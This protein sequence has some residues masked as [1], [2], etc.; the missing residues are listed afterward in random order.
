MRDHDEIDRLLRET[1]ER[2]RARPLPLPAVDET[3]FLGSA[4]GRSASISRFLAAVAAGVLVIALV[5]IVASRTAPANPANTGIGLAATPTSAASMTTAETSPPSPAPSAATSAPSPSSTVSP[6]PTLVSP[7]IVRD[8]DAVVG[9]GNLFATDDRLRSLLYPFAGWAP[10]TVIVSVR[11]VDARDLPGSET[12]PYVPD[13]PG[14]TWVT[15]WVRVTGVWSDDALMAG[16]VDLADQPSLFELAQMPD[17]PCD[18]PTSGLPRYTG[19][20]GDAERAR[21]AFEALEAE[22]SRDPDTYSG[23]SSAVIRDPDDGRVDQAIVVGTVLEV[24]SVAQRLHAIYPYKPCILR[25]DHSARELQQA[26]EE[27]RALKQPWDVGDFEYGFG[28]VIVRVPV[29][30]DETADTLARFG[31]IITI[32]PIVSA[33]HE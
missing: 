3:M 13:L 14:G 2:W 15:S 24:E 33:L 32:R 26:A 1:G 6:A 27:V 20:P 18:P 12:D 29:L 10:N 17:V 16:R 5:A 30:D 11:G 22:I 21:E 4:A 8:G 23:I 7:A 28:R 19:A 31:S 25:V 9:E